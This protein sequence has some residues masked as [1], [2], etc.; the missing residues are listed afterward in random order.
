MS[1]HGA[2][3]AR[4]TRRFTG[5]SESG[6]AYLEPAR[7]AEILIPPRVRR[8]RGATFA[9]AVHLSRRRFLQLS[10]DP[11]YGPYQPYTFM[12]MDIDLVSVSDDVSVLSGWNLPLQ[13]IPDFRWAFGAALLGAY[14]T[15]GWVRAAQR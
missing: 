9:R 11:S 4:R 6:R 5:A 7:R 8:A 10:S 1:T 2:T 15:V 13:N 12:S 14:L 3:P